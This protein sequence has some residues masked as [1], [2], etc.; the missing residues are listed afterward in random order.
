MSISVCVIRCPR[1]LYNEDA[2]NRIILSLEM[3]KR[4]REVTPPQHGGIIHQLVAMNPPGFA[5]K[6]LT[7]SSMNSQTCLLSVTAITHRKVFKN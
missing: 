3:P 7:A 2:T 1:L 4:Q 5:L 6:E